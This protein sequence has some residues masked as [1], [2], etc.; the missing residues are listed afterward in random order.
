MSPYA[1]QESQSS[2]SPEREAHNRSHNVIVGS[3]PMDACGVFILD[4]LGDIITFKMHKEIYTFW[5]RISFVEKIV[6]EN[7]RDTRKPL[8]KNGAMGR[9]VAFL[10]KLRNEGTEGILRD[11]KDYFAVSLT[12]EAKAGAI[13]NHLESTAAILY[14][15]SNR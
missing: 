10:V 3:I 9:V 2:L 12:D 4:S 13:D 8:S 15:S 11:E 6:A 5:E 1:T 7:Y 14:S